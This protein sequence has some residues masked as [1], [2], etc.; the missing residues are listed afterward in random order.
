[1]R[2][3]SPTMTDDGRRQIV[4]GPHW[5]F[6]RQIEQ[7]ASKKLQKKQD[8]QPSAMIS[9]LHFRAPQQQHLSDTA[10]ISNLPN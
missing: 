6:L 9:L 7:Q 8:A 1:M 10:L 3:N 5:M 2:M 4:V